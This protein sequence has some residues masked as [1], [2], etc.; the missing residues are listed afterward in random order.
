MY[1]AREIEILDYVRKTIKNSLKYKIS[2][3]FVDICTLYHDIFCLQFNHKRSLRVISS[4]ISDGRD[5]TCGPG[6]TAH[7]DTSFIKYDEARGLPWLFLC[8]QR[9]R[10]HPCSSLDSRGRPPLR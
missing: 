7:K 6:F 10:K 1:T 3:T 4:T 9:T 5:L 8:P 2:Y